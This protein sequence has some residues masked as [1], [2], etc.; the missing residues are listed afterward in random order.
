MYGS[1]VD[2]SISQ[3]MV[4]DM[5]VVDRTKGY[6]RSARLVE[7]LLHHHARWMIGRRTYVNVALSERRLMHHLSSQAVYCDNFSPLVFSRG[8][9]ISDSI[10]ASL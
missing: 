2:V 4:V 3:V 9:S 6:W 8:V 10:I 1:C 5:R 7:L